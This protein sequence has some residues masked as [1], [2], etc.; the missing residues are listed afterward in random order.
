MKKSILITFGLLGCVFASTFGQGLVSSSTLQVESGA[1]LYVKG[2]MKNNAGGTVSNAGEIR[3][4][5]N[6]DNS[7]TS[8]INSLVVLDGTGNQSVSGT[9]DFR[10]VLQVS[11][12]GGVATVS[13]GTTKVHGILRLDEGQMNANGNLVIAST[14]SGTGLVDDFSDLSYDGQLIGNLRVQR[15]IQG[16]EGFHYVGTPVNTANVAEL[17]EIGLYGPDGGQ[18]IPQSNCDPLNIDIGSPYGAMMEWRENGPWLVAG[19]QQS[20]WFVRSSGTMTN[21]RGYGIITGG[22]F[23]VE[24]GGAVGNTAETPSQASSVSYNGLANTN[25]TGNGWHMVSN[26]FPSPIQW[27]AAPV[28]FDGQAQKWITSGSYSGTYQAILPSGSPGASMLGSMQGFFIRAQGGPVNFA[29]DQ[30]YR[31]LGDPVFYKEELSNTFD[32]VVRTAGFADKTRVRFGDLDE[33]NDFDPMLDANKLKARGAQPTLQ[34]RIGDVDYSINSLPIEGHP[35]TIPMDLFPGV[36]GDFTFTAEYLDQFTVEAHVYLEDLKEGVIQELTVNPLYAFTADESDDPERFLL[37]FRLNGE[38]PLYTG[39]DMMM[40][41]NDH[42]AYV[43]LPEFEGKASLEV[44]NALGEVVYQTST[45][46]EG[47]NS[48]DL[49]FLATGPYIMRVLVDGKPTTKKVVL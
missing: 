25:A 43:F 14:A 17:S 29:L 34:T 33:S 31:R 38:D 49:N 41:A 42:T 7:G 22:G 13:S 46:Y 44:F 37:H 12:T 40:Y 11:K 47:K 1:V 16:V 3:I 30:S 15:L 5:G 19:C 6:F 24:I 48:F 28:G 18:I 2:D 8:T 45:L 35:M 36:S 39:D 21:G 32:I 23:T 9:T 26:P 20:G 4:S 10:D 27:Y